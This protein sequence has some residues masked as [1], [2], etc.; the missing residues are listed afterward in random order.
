[1]VGLANRICMPTHACSV[2]PN[3]VAKVKGERATLVGPE[4]SD[5]V[6]MSALTL[7]RPVDRGYVVDWALQKEIW[8]K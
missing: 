6:D 3:A 8:A 1:M 7:R 2:F 4:I 5:A